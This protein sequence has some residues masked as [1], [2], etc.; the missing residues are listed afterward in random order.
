MWNQPQRVDA[1]V[2]DRSMNTL[3]PITHPRRIL[4]LLLMLSIAVIALDPSIARSQ[5]VC[6]PS[7]RLL[8]IVPMGAQVG[9]SVEVSISGENLDEVEGL[10]FSES[11]ITAKPVLDDKHAII[12]K[13]YRITIP[14]DIA[15]GIVEA[16]AIARLG[17]SSSRVF[18]IGT[19]PEF[20][21]TAPSSSIKDAHPLKI[22]S[23][24]NATMVAR[25][26]NYYRFSATAGEKFR[27]HCAS[28]GI[29]SKL[30]PVLIFTN[31]SGRV[32][33][34]DR[35]DSGIDYQVE[36]D[37]E[38]FIQVHDLTFRGGPEFFY[39]LSLQKAAGETVGHVA[40]STRHVGQYS[41]PPYG[42]D[43]TLSKS[44]AE[45]N[46]AKQAQ[47]ITL[48]CQLSGSFF[49][50]AD[51]D[52]YEFQASKGQQWWIEIASHRLGVATGPAA[53]VQR[54]VQSDSG[55]NWVDVLELKDIASPMKVSSNSYAYDGPPVNGGS[56]DLIGK[57]DI[58]SDGLYRLQLNDLFGGTRDNPNNTYQLVIRPATADFALTGWVK[59]MELRNG[60]RNAL[61]KPLA[62]R[63]GTTIAME[64]GAFRRDEFQE[65]IRLEVI[66][67]PDGVIASTID[68]PAG[69]TSGTVLLTATDQ[70]P[71]GL[72][73]IS[74]VGHATVSGRTETRRCQIASMA[75][76]IRDH[77]QEF[78]RPRLSQVVPVSVTNSELNT[79]SIRSMS[80]PLDDS[81]F[82]AVAKST[83]TI[84]LQLERRCEFSGSVL[85]L[86]TLGNGFQ[87]NARFEIPLQENRADAKLDLA[88]LN[89]APG[90][91]TLAFYGAAVAKYRDYPGALTRA[92]EVKQSIVSRVEQ[93]QQQ[94][95]S[96]K[97]SGQQTN[98]TSLVSLEQEL[99][100]AEAA[101]SAADNELK[102]ATARS[103][104]QDIADIVV[105]RP[106]TLEVLP[107]EEKK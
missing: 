75:W 89:V 33:A 18:S 39:R 67:L 55:T 46:D 30:D 43:S 45:P 48:P 32:L 20:L 77:W 41:W 104:P 56:T 98:A 26:M 4:V 60:D 6:L 101:L 15:P 91:Y 47:R 68:I 58:P 99:K 10:I 2:N 86:H 66:G 93:L 73:F 106:F 35:L 34:T 36:H 94:I 16:Y 14:P 57:L 74:I 70:A 90:V 22:G 17:V 1:K 7:P 83:V 69:Q 23:T 21:Q 107:A 81:R 92:E 50:A 59:H 62:L 28:R 88:K 95:K 52:C 103:R 54:A 25:G 42:F 97:T 96:L 11:R 12:P 24:T 82:R 87:S 76:P 27:I 100:A 63:P 5:S 72:G 51:V 65:P 8:T 3:H 78:P 44:E 71:K 37:G 31:S 53:L 13:R 40:A 84:P 102:L 19:I 105:T 79:I 49:P 9:T 64:I 85:T 29:D 80:E 38:Y 61:S